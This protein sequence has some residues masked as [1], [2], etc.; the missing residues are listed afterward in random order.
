MSTNQA[1]KRSFKTQ[2]FSLEVTSEETENKRN[3]K[4]VTFK[5]YR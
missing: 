1:T 2:S 3:K 5:N 4:K